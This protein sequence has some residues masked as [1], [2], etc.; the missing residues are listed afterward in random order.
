MIPA[1]KRYP[2]HAL[3]IDVCD[4]RCVMDL[5][6]YMDMFCLFYQMFRGFV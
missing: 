4:H 1:V 3:N 2:K 5:M 6:I